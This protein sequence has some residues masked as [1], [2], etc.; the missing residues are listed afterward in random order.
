MALGEEF[1]RYTGES[2]LDIYIRAD[3][4]RKLNA[5]R[6]GSWSQRVRSQKHCTFLLL[7]NSSLYTRT[8]RSSREQYLVKGSE[9]TVGLHYNSYVGLVSNTIVVGGVHEAVA[10]DNMGSYYHIA[11]FTI[12]YYDTTTV[13]R[14]CEQYEQQ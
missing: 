11:R 12:D 13:L 9:F 10:S 6:H 5:W 8:C 14:Y 7:L 1:G 2:F 4:G 3:G